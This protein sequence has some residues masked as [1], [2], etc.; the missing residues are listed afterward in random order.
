MMK[1]TFTTLLYLFSSL[2][3]ANAAI[4]GSSP[5]FGVKSFGGHAASWYDMNPVWLMFGQMIAL[6]FLSC[7]SSKPVIE[8]RCQFFDTRHKTANTSPTDLHREAY[9]WIPT[10]SKR[11]LNVWSMSSCT[12]WYTWLNQAATAASSHWWI[13]TCLNGIFKGKSSTGCRSNMRAGNI[14]LKPSHFRSL[15]TM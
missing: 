7:A 15:N 6:I 13:N 1:E 3:H 5:F 2:L 14:N 11:R 4:L 10:W 8:T 9:D 12:R